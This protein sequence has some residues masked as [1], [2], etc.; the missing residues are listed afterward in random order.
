MGNSP[1]STT[2]SHLLSPTPR[3]ASVS[4]RSRLSSFTK[5]S[6]SNSIYNEILKD[7]EKLRQSDRKANYNPHRRIESIASNLPT[8]LQNYSNTIHTVNEFWLNSIQTLPE[9]ELNELVTVCYCRLYLQCKTVRDILLFTHGRKV[10]NVFGYV[11]R[12]LV[13]PSNH[14]KL[15]RQLQMLGNMHSSYSLQNETYEL[16][17]DAF[18]FA[19]EEK[20][21]KDYKI[22]TRFCFGQLYR[23]IVDI[24]TG[25]DFYSVTTR[26][27]QNNAENKA[28]S[29]ILR[30]KRFSS[31]H[32]DKKELQSIQPIH[33]VDTSSSS[34]INDDEFDDDELNRLQSPRKK[35]KSFNYTQIDSFLGSLEECLSDEKGSLYF[36]KYLEEQFCVEN[37]LFH[38]FVLKYKASKSA[39]RIKVGQ[40]IIDE[41]VQIGSEKEVNLSYNTRKQILTIVNLVKKMNENKEKYQQIYNK[42]KMSMIINEDDIKYLNNE[43]ENRHYRMATTKK[44]PIEL[45]E[46]TNLQNEDIPDLIYSMG[47]T[48]NLFDKAYDEIFKLMRR[49]CWAGFRNKILGYCDDKE[50]VKRQNEKIREKK[51]EQRKQRKMINAIHFNSKREKRVTIN[52]NSETNTTNLVLNNGSVVYHGELKDDDFGHSDIE[53][54]QLNE[55]TI[56]DNDNVDDVPEDFSP[57]IMLDNS[58]TSIYD[59]YKIVNF[60][61]EQNLRNI[62][63]IKQKQKSLLLPETS[64]SI[65]P[66]SELKLPIQLTTSRTSATKLF[67]SK[68]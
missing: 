51:E 48:A 59:L 25:D 8:Q 56:N 11:I 35:K 30:L 41:F 22:R 44:L 63:K 60:N 4:S 28:L 17:L 2:G 1:T 7:A 13:D 6:G 31:A 40:L 61:A 36:K 5:G 29:P 62:E 46:I 64:I 9:T 33:G 19:M 16:F 23:V 21:K 18:N 53:L 37:F 47:Y 27:I 43:N 20:F 55:E 68:T 3:H 67:P 54:E 42:N 50:F 15:F 32:K 38:E 24:M 39:Q 49:N 58:T 65:S 12:N 45:F 52:E 57:P 10:F 34:N 14:I 26:L 66:K